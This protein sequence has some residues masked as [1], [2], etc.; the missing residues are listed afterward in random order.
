MCLNEAK[1]KFSVHGKHTC[2]LLLALG[3]QHLLQNVHYG[4]GFHGWGSVSNF[5]F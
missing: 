3:F 2:S 4:T 5:G 1:I